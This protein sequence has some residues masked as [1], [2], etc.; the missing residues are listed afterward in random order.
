MPGTEV[1]HPNVSTAAGR[2][3]AT[4]RGGARLGKLFGIEIEVD[5]SWFFIFILVTWNLAA[6]FSQ[7]H[8][9]WGLGL[10][11]GTALAASLLF[12]ASVLAHELAHSLVARARGL[13]VRRITLFLFG[14]VSNL[15]R[16][17]AS[18]GTEFVMAVVGP[19]TSVLLGFAFLTLGSGVSGGV[20]V[21]LS[22]PL[23]ALARLDPLSTLLL[24][25]GPINI[26]VGLF[27]LV[28]AFP[29]DGGRI[30]RSL[31]WAAT[32]NL[33]KA[34]RWASQV[35][36]LIAWSF[37]FAGIAM[38][39]GARLPFF[40]SGL[41]GGLWI[42]LIG[43]FLNNAAMVTYR[44]LVVY[45]L[46][47]GVPVSRLMRRDTPTVPSDIA[48]SQ[49]VHDFLIGTDERAFPVLDGNRLAGL[50][51]L[52]DVRKVPRD[53]WDGTL[54]RQIMTPRQQLS[55]IPPQ[56]D[57]AAALR[58]ITRLDVRQVPVVENDRLVGLLR[59]RDFVRWLHL[60]SDVSAI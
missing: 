40:G 21:T 50:V 51:C 15:E 37:I 46:L 57:A 22:N 58:E 11:V 30:L 47:E 16:E 31:L 53:R 43:W 8:P 42:A 49:L 12:F 2:G 33:Q 14:G 20:Q 56:E 18:P 34:T 28:P 35:G 10:R 54:V 41:I 7:W 25:L 5:A 13:P 44:Q 39:F 17:P 23:N 19:L 45:D 24:W 32:K 3:R 52:E 38:I 36:R 29:L 1:S 59:R 48:V 9:G 26:L 55:V 60:H 27:N 4:R 6:G